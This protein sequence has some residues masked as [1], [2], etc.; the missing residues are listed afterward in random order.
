VR[1]I[2]F[3]LA[4]C[5]ALFP[6]CHVKSHRLVITEEVAPGMN[7]DTADYTDGATHVVSR[8]AHF[9]NA[10]TGDHSVSGD[11][12]AVFLAVTGKKT[13]GP[14]A[15]R[16]IPAL[17]TAIE[18]EGVKLKAQAAEK[19]EESPVAPKVRVFSVSH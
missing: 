2:E 9:Y 18:K 10:P 5:V 3:A 1:T 13:V 12:D 16:S 7:T 14:L 15:T 11:F 17:L 8:V 19:V 4:A 6:G